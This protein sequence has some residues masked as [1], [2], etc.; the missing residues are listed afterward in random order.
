MS[1]TKRFPSQMVMRLLVALATAALLLAAMAPGAHAAPGAAGSQKLMK[2]ARLGTTRITGGPAQ[3]H[4]SGP[5]AG[6]VRPEP[7][8]GGGGDGGG[9]QGGGSQNGAPSPPFRNLQNATNT[10]HVKGLTHFDQRFAG[11]GDYTNTQF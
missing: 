8:E 1:V 5:L 4:A 11:T 2:L 3:V 10:P 6:E 9:N 7:E